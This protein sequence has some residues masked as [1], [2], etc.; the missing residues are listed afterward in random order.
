MER[1]QRPTRP[2]P[3]VLAVLRLAA[4]VV[5]AAALLGVGLHDAGRSARPDV[6]LTGSGHAASTAP[7]TQPSVIAMTVGSSA[8]TTTTPPSQPAT[9][10]AVPAKT[11]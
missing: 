9:T 1:M 2:L 11:S 7:Y 3:S 8:T 5:A 10:K 4:S 6:A